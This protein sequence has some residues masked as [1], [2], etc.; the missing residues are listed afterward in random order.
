M[1]SE[2]RRPSDSAA[3]A[4]ARRCAG[5]QYETAASFQLPAPSFKLPADNSQRS[6]NSGKRQAFAKRL[7]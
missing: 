3:R 5:S 2:G 7:L 1:S 4:L 6:V